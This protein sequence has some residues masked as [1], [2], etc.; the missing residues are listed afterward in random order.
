VLLLYILPLNWISAGGCGACCF[1]AGVVT[2]CFTENQKKGNY[3]TENSK[4]KYWYSKSILSFLFISVQ[5]VARG[6]DQVDGMV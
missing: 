6:T 3:C 1:A 2:N 5:S 4:P